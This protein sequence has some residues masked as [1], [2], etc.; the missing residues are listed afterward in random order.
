MKINF[1]FIFIL[2]F[3]LSYEENSIIQIPNIKQRIIKDIKTKNGL[4][5]YGFNVIIE[6]T[7]LCVPSIFSQ[8]HLSKMKNLN[9]FELPKKTA[10]KEYIIEGKK[11]IY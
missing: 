2:F 7:G 6:D 1:L 5:D 8:C 3:S 9:L 11:K 10:F 4:I